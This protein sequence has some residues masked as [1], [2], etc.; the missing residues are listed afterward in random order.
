M[1][2]FKIATLTG[3]LLFIPFVSF[4]RTFE[5]TF[6]NE[7]TV[8]VHITAS[9]FDDL[10]SPGTNC[11]SNPGSWAFN[12]GNVNPGDTPTS[13]F[14]KTDYADKTF[15]YV[16]P[17]GTY[18]EV[19]VMWGSLATSWGNLYNITSCSYATLY[20]ESFTMPHESSST[21]PEPGPASST[22]TSSTQQI[23]NKGPNLAGL[24]ALFSSLLGS[25]IWIR[26]S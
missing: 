15:D 5:W 2:K 12:V 23:T 11:G 1:S 16:L 19:G 14:A 24:I 3:L 6:P 8:R 7:N 26:T 20:T 25:L 10:I 13:I 18:S 22:I 9:S 21:P 4:A 17:D